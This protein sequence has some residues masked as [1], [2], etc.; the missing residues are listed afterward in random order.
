MRDDDRR[1]ADILEA[2]RAVLRFVEGRDES[3]LAQDEMLVA[4][5][6]QKIVVIGEAA[7]SVSEDRRRAMDEL[8][9]REMIGMRNLVAHHYWRV[10]PQI[11]WA[12]VRRDLPAL[13]S[14]LEAAGVGRS[15]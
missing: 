6:L 7:A 4:A 9:W 10:E 14:Q 2:A 1:L 5:L 3:D 11:L 13:I 15:E 8:P 12:T